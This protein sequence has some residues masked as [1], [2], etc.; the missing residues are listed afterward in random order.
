[1]AYAHTLVGCCL[2]N[3][4]TNRYHPIIYR[5]AP[6]PGGSDLP[7]YKSSGHHTDGCDTLA[8]A[9]DVMTTKMHEIEF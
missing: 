4:A 5:P 8:E 9:R 6:L 2:L 7:R 3:T 1:M